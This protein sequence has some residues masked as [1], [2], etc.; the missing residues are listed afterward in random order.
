M[1]LPGSSAYQVQRQQDE[2]KSLKMIIEK[3]SSKLR[4]YQFQVHSAGGN[5]NEDNV[6]FLGTLEDPALETIAS[7]GG[8]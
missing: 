2:I 6:L 7:G 3:L 1:P 4:D 8:G 5:N